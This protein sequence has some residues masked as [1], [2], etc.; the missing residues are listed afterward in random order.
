MSAV[1]VPFVYALRAK[2]LRVGAT[3]LLALGRALVRGVHESS[4]TGF[5]Y[6]A[7]SLFCHSETEL[8]AFDEAFAAH[9]RGVE[10]AHALVLDE[11]E[12]WLR[13][14]AELAY[15]SAEQRA[16]LQSLD[17]AELRRLFEE[18]LREQRERHDGGSRFIGTGGTSPFGAGGTHPTGLRV[19]A[20]GGARSAIGVA[21]ARL[22]R[23]YRSDL[24]LD[25]RQI[26]VA[27]RKLRSFTREGAEEEL[28]LD[29]SIDATA[30]NAGE[31]EI[32]TRPP[33]RPNVRVV[34]L[35]DV[36]GSMDPHIRLVSELFSAAKRA[37]NFRSLECY[38]FHNAIYGQV[39]QSESFREPVPV[40][41]I[42]RR[43]EGDKWHLIVVG[44]AAM[45]P[46]E[47]LSDGPW[48][49]AHAEADERLSALDWFTTLAD[50]FKHAA[51]LNP[52]PPQ[53]WN[54]G[55]VRQLAAVF[56]MFPLT[57]DGL[58]EAMRHLSSGRA[59]RR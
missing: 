20:H 40:G 51:W 27:L 15:L 10:E 8:D 9:F 19:G 14:P 13:D 57:L 2:K 41:D 47:L 37:S 38:Y 56:R 39:F 12:G 30:R 4:L 17:L 52:D 31:L 18:R 36:G 46:G 32:V 21:D 7:R 54:A 42:L 28:D 29:G 23:P 44:D 59:L 53:Y 25:V 33:R 43:T 1:L 50:H 5:Y 58:G 35:M 34:L 24:V 3:E 16:L 22:F 48:Y 6:V 45:H 55:T 49:R 26:E 11:L